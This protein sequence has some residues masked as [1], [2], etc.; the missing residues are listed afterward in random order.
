MYHP[1][2][3]QGI[4]VVVTGGGRGIGLEVVRQFLG[5][6]ARVVVHMGG[7]SP[8][9]A[10]NFSTLQR[11]R[12][13]RSSRR[14]ISLA[15]GG[16]ESLA[17]VVRSRFDSVDVLVN[18]AGT[19]VGRFP[20]SDLTDEAI[21]HVV[22]PQPDLVVEMTRTMLPLLRKG[23]HPAIVTRFRSRRAWAA[24]PALRSTLPPKLSSQPIRR[25]WR[26]NLRRTASVSTASRP[27]RSRRIFHERYSTPEKLEA[28]RKTIPLGRL[29]TAEDCAR[30][31]S[32]S[33]RT[34]FRA[35]SPARSWR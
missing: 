17:D 31:I 21:P 2:L 28:T 29:G 14:R 33:P 22:R 24:V 25:R 1:A 34:R 18:N 27:A 20:A 12:A 4:N 13:G 11:P 3:F 32:S 35:I 8:P 5:C 15:D 16:V 6:G 9:T 30:P 23:R 26:V 19:M 10:P 7:R